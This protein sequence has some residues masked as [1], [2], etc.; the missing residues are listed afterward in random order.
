MTA[1]L[2]AR[3]RIAFNAHVGD[4]RYPCL[5]AKGLAARDD[6]DLQV[7]GGLGSAGA[8]QALTRDLAAFVRSMTR[9]RTRALTA[10]VAVFTRRPSMSEAEFE[11][12]L[13]M[14]L[15]RLHDADDSGSTWDPSVSGDPDDP[16][17]SFSFA[18]SALFVIGLHPQSARIA[19]RF[20]WPALVFN[21]HAQFERLR[22]DGHYDRLRDGI[23]ARDLALQG[24]LNP[25]LAD[26][27]ERSEARQ[28]SG[29]DNS[30]ASWRCPFHPR[31]P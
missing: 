6:Y 14:Q 30:S 8:T 5:A 7:Y 28:Y 21:P 15:Q 25:N 26:F 22:R 11:R 13:W 18:G 4:A 23:R 20:P 3:V 1:H 29:R 10:F 19:R 31:K 17:F 16:R 12:R 9:D 24:T 27:G 2:E